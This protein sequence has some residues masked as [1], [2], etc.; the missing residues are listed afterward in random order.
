MDPKV[1]PNLNEI[2]NSYNTSL[3]NKNEIEARFGVFGKS[4]EPGVNYE[5]F[6]RIYK[7]FASKKEIYT[8]NKRQQSIV[9]YDNNTKEIVEKGK[10]VF[11]KKT[12]INTFDIKPYGVRIAM[13]REDNV[14]NVVKTSLRKVSEMERTRI[15]FSYKDLFQFDLDRTSTGEMT[16]ELESTADFETFMKNINLILQILQDAE[17]IIS[18]QERDSV[19]NFYKKTFSTK[20]IG[21]QPETLVLEKIY[22]EEDYACTK[23]L[24]GKRFILLIYRNQCY[25]MSNNMID[26]KKIPYTSSVKEDVLIDGEYFKGNFYAFDLI[27]TQGGI[28]NRIE[29][30]RTIFQR[31]RVYDEKK[32]FTK[33]QIKDYVYGNLYNSLSSLRSNLNDKYEDGLIVIKANTDYF[34]SFPLKW[35]KTERL[36]IDFLIKKAEG[37]FF[38]YVQDKN[39]LHLFAKNE[40]QE[41]SKYKDGDIVECWYNEGKWLP[42]HPRPDKKKPNYITVANDNM[43]AILSPF[44]FEKVKYYS[45]RSKAVFYNL[46]RFHNFIKRVTLEKY[47]KNKKNLLDLASGKG[48]DFGKYRDIG[49]KYVEAYE[50]D[51]ESIIISKTRLLGI[52]EDKKN[53]I[54][55]EV[56]KKDLNESSV[57]SEVTFD[58]VVCNFAF[59]YFYNKLDH[60]VQNVKSNTKKGSL[61]VL[62]FFDNE[63]IIEHDNSNSK[64]IKIGEDQI[65]VY[66]KDSVLNKPTREHIVNKKILIEKLKEKGLVVISEKNFSEFYD[67]WK[68]KGNALSEEEKLFSFMNIELVL[69]VT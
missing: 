52:T 64:I 34:N 36:T 63:K 10:S 14:D 25:L 1:I 69:Q 15:T 22:K 19:L 47:G 4:F 7:F 45:S 17:V 42:L 61:V 32:F 58:I 59:H 40:V 6:N 48:G 16:V 21:I 50:I 65:D 5:Q 30:I 55:I 39:S 8:M 38:F 31:C 20:F 23:K 56:N 57:K 44:D 33:L 62:T 26:F 49:I 46:R 29:S 51:E 12:K 27:S 67:Q 35:K 3:S 66:I 37:M 53:S 13:S 28:S 60:F 11:M 43:K 18:Q 41:Y 68:S 2:Y 54:K 24:D 9:R